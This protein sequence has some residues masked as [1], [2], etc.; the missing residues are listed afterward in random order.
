MQLAINIP[1]LWAICMGFGKHLKRVMSTFVHSPHFAQ[2][3][4]GLGWTGR[5]VRVCR[6]YTTMRLPGLKKLI[7]TRVLLL[8]CIW[9]LC[10]AGFLMHVRRRPPHDAGHLK[11]HTHTHTLSDTNWPPDRTDLYSNRLSAMWLSR[12]LSGRRTDTQLDSPAHTH[13][14]SLY[15]TD[16]RM[17]ACYEAAEKR[18]SRWITQQL[19]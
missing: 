9:S 7:S 6:R 14:H 11:T 2:K 8:C 19:S 16:R 4:W 5:L 1:Q 13:T 12:T 3:H 15:I 17:S 18:P 10:C